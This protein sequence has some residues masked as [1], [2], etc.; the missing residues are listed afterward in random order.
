MAD[1]FSTM[2]ASAS[3]NNDPFHDVVLVVDPYSTGCLIAKEISMR[4]YQIAAVWTAGFS[5][6]MKTH[7]PQ[8]VGGKMEYSFEVEE[9]AD[10]LAKTAD[11]C[12]EAAAKAGYTIKACLAG[13]EAGVVLADK[14]SEFLKLRTNGT[15]VA[16]RCDKKMQQELIRKVG[17]RSVRQACSDKFAEV[18]GFLKTESYPV[19]LKPNE[20]AGS[21]GVKLC[22]SFAEATEH[23]QVLMKSQM[24]NGGDVP[25]VLCQEFLKGRE[26]VVDHVSQNGVHKTMMVRF[27]FVYILFCILL[28]FITCLYFWR[29]LLFFH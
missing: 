23:F 29:G 2:M 7:V 14:L 1:S 4:G 21:D 28:E 27:C 16:N 17:L 9:T 15:E 10:D 19:V 25:A 3:L 22:H 20:S 11:L 13:G 5:E 12:K 8:S 18:E 6:E 24:V 26:Y